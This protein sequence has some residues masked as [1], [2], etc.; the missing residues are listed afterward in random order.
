MG[1]NARRMRGLP[2]RRKG[3]R[4]KRCRYRCKSW[5]AFLDSMDLIER[6]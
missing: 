4:G 3:Y 6:M 2:F 1:N 5:E